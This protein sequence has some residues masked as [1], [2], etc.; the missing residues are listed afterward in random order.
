MLNQLLVNPHPQDGVHRSTIPCEIRV[1]DVQ[2]SPPVFQG[3]LTA[4]V[5]EDAPIGTDVLTIL[6]KDGDRGDPRLVVYDLVTS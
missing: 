2:N 4:T 1:L 3:P 5:Q 6:A